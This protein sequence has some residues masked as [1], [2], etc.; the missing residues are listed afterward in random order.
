M[1][2][3]LTDIVRKQS[4]ISLIGIFNRVVEKVVENLADD[5]LRD[6]EFREQMRQLVRVA[7][8]QALKEL[9]EPAQPIE[10]RRYP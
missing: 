2:T 9:N 10:P 4:A 5:L 1:S 3:L 6:P 7:F 8:Q